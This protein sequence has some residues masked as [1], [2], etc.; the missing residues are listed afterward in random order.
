MPPKFDPA[1][2]LVIDEVGPW[3][4]EKHE[5]LRKYITAS[6]GARA[7]F[8]PP[9]NTGGASFVELFSGPGRSLIRDTGRIVDG[10]PLVACKAAT[11][12]GARF[13]EFH[14]ADIEQANSVALAARMAALG[15]SPKT[16][17][18]PAE[19][20]VDQ[21]VANLNPYGLHF[22]FLDPYNLEEL[23]FSIIEKLAKMRRMDMLIHVSVQ[24]LQ[25]N[26][27][28]YSQAG[29]VLDK[30]MPGWRDHVDIRQAIAP[31]RAALLDYWLKQIT[32][33]GTDP[34]KGELV[35]GGGG[36]RLYWLVFVS[37]NDLG[38]KLW[39][40]VRDIRGQS[41]LGL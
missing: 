28:R 39:K 1:D 3:A 18:G 24:D 38:Q 29:D 14:F 23:P 9:A 26:L 16:Y 33:L 41:E 8:L 2:G 27:D 40:A 31:L 25:R 35:T 4:S 6:R 34:A 36:Q 22:A 15:H 20:T 21:V 30:F 37:A 11:A 7:K 12:S 13:S 19:A 32:A 17:V 5:R 10:S